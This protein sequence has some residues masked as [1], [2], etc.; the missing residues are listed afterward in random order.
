MRL[1]GLRTGRATCRQYLLHCGQSVPCIC[2]SLYI[3]PSDG[4]SRSDRHA[5]ED[6]SSQIREI[7]QYLPAGHCQFDLTIRVLALRHQPLKANF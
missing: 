5:L 2:Q 4:F 6:L 1:A 7:V 3:D